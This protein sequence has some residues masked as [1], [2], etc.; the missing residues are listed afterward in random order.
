V[1]AGTGIYAD[2][3]LLVAII[4]IERHGFM[5]HGGRQIVDAV[6]AGILQGAQ[7]DGFAG[8]GQAAN[9]YQAHFPDP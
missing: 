5:Q 4:G 2:G 6:E 9:Q 8:A 3:N 1:R 7:G